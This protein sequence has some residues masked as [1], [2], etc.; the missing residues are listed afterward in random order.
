MLIT[1]IEIIHQIMHTCFVNNVASLKRSEPQL[2]LLICL[3]ELHVFFRFTALV[4]K[5]QNFNAH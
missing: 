1:I 5:V 4:D 2:C 3:T